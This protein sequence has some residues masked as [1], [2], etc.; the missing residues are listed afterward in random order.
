MKYNVIDYYDNYLIKDG[1]DFVWECNGVGVTDIYIQL[2]EDVTDA[3]I[4]AILR[5]RNLL[6]LQATVETVLV[7]WID[8]HWCELTD[9]ETGEPLYRLVKAENY[10]NE[11]IG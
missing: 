2:D 4:I 9:A 1:E 6:S 10:G 3:D 8:E 5:E 7:E 11:V